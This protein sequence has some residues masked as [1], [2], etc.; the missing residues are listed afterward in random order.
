MTLKEEV[1][2][3][4]KYFMLKVKKQ[5]TVEHLTKESFFKFHA[6]TKCQWICILIY[7]NR[8]DTH[9]LISNQK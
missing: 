8:R 3:I 5:T 1:I 9:T 6:Y 7:N 2:K 4:L